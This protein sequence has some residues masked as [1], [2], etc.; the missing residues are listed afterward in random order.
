MLRAQLWCSSWKG[1]GTI[2]KR[3]ERGEG[4]GADRAG[5]ERSLIGAGLPGDSAAQLRISF[6]RLH[7]A[8]RR[9]TP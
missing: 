1:E 4:W 2:H 8:R 3:G 7:A 9:G 5:G 6:R